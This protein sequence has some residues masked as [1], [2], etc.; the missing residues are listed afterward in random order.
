HFPFNG[1]AE[2]ESGYGNHGQVFGATLTEDRFGTPERAYAFDGID[3]YIL[4][5]NP[6]ALH[7]AKNLSVSFWAKGTSNDTSFAG[8]ITSPNMQPFGLAMNDKGRIL[9]S[10]SS[11]SIPL[12]LVDSD[13]NIK[14]NDWHQYVAVY[15]ANEYLKLFKDGNLS[16]ALYGTIPGFM[17]IG[18]SGVY[19]GALS[20]SYPGIEEISFFSGSIDDIRFYNHALTNED[21]NRLYE[22]ERTIPVRTEVDLEFPSKFQLYQNYPNPFNPTTNISFDLPST[23]V[24][25]LKV[26]DMTGRL[27]ITLIDGR[28]PAGSHQITF[29]ASQL[30]SGVYLYELKGAGYSNIKKLTLIK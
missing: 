17:D 2:D 21:I 14:P 1:N 6:T 15:Q 13:M 16:A 7:T 26:Y 10:I 23:A 30:A 3:D 5:E 4:I 8:L 29:D 28:I 19:I 27:I 18:S 11:E 9:F 12:N 25:S 24:I 20:I 22:K